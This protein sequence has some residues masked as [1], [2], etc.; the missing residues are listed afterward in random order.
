MPT[1]LMEGGSSYGQHPASY[2]QNFG[3][4]ASSNYQRDDY[5]DYQNEDSVWGTAKKWAVA[6]GNNLAAAEHEVWKKINKD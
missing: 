2:Q 1:T 5:D 3:Q 4:P 6:A